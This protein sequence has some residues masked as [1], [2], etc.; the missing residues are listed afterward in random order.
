MHRLVSGPLD[1]EPRPAAGSTEVNKLR[2]LPARRAA[3]CWLTTG[4][5]LDGLANG[6][7]YCPD[8]RA[9]LAGVHSM[10]GPIVGLPY[11]TTAL[12]RRRR[13]VA[14]VPLGSQPTCET[15][16]CSRPVFVDM[17]YATTAASITRRPMEDAGV[18][19]TRLGRS[20]PAERYW[21]VPLVGQRSVALGRVARIK[22]S[23]ICHASVAV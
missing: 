7:N 15:I 20:L 8:R 6:E 19:A 21:H 23:H 11:G 17:D 9:T 16:Y 13:P 1:C 18:A 14:G 5:L 4:S 12:A 22:N 10:I 3:H 2:L